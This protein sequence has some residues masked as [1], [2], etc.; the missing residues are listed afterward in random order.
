MSVYMKEVATFLR[1]LYL[2]RGHN[3]KRPICY[4]LLLAMSMSSFAQE[5]DLFRKAGH[6][7]ELKTISVSPDNKY[8]I[9]LEKDTLA[10]LWDIATGQQLRTIKN[11]EGASFK[12]NSSIYLAMCDKTFK[13]IDLDGRTIKTYAS[14]GAKYKFINTR[15]YNLIPKMFYPEKGLYFFGDDVFDM[16]KGYVRRLDTQMPGYGS[17]DYSPATNQMAIADEKTGKVSFVSIETGQVL[18][19]VQTD[20]LKNEDINLSFSP[21]GEKLLLAKRSAFLLI[22]V[23]SATIQRTIKNSKEHGEFGAFSPDGEMLALV[24]DD[25]EKKIGQIIMLDIKSGAVLFRRIFKELS[26]FANMQFTP[27]GKSFGLWFSGDM[28]NKET[29]FLLDA[30]KGTS[31]W[32]YTWLCKPEES[33]VNGSNITFSPDGQKMVFGNRKK[34]RLVGANSGLVEKTFAEISQGAVNGLHFIDDNSRMA[35]STREQIFI[36]NLQTGE[37]ERSLFIKEKNVEERTIK[38]APS[39]DG[40]TFFLIRENNL[41]EIDSSGKTTF[42]YAGTKKMEYRGAL[43]V[44]YD[45]QYVMNQGTPL[46]G[47]CAANKEA[48]TL[49]V[50][51]TKTHRL[52]Y[53]N[54]CV[55]GI[56]TFAKT[57]NMLLIKE[58]S[59]AELLKFYELPSGK[60]LYQIKVPKTSF[61]YKKPVFSQSDRY[62]TMSEEIDYKA[63]YAKEILIDLKTKSVKTIPVT[64][65]VSVIRGKDLY[66]TS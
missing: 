45:G 44:S 34:L 58:H 16:D 51:D 7:S 56:V 33:S 13:E 48:S 23:P 42:Q 54:N 12:T 46:T 38:Y 41:I 25:D 20:N 26:F 36:W 19:T 15:S 52:V 5:S 24:D 3:I 14:V 37:M 65:P 31:S 50:F 64:K 22:D 39:G 27:D 63:D 28:D 10:I 61:Q 21:N 66:P 59:N 53:T 30:K 6:K 43:A 55:D 11:V 1:L 4:L 47:F 62:V 49:E 35:S 2:T 8:F 29:M 57:Q 32:Q 17:R 60:L 18:R 9:S 40:K